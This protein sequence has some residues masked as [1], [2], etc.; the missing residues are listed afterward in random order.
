MELK[1][2]LSLVAMETLV[3][4]VL[5]IYLYWVDGHDGLVYKIEVINIEAA[6]LEGDIMIPTSIEFPE[7]LEEL[8]FALPGE[9]KD[10][11]I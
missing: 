1:E 9:S 2:L 3:Q 6:F 4:V 10:Y 8:Q 11:C 7:G 5:C